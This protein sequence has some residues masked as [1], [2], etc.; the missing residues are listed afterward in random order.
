MLNT[1]DQ[2]QLA[3]DRA[4]NLYMRANAN[5]QYSEAARAVEA[6]VK[7]VELRLALEREKGAP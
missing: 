6:M 4:D 1:E 5:G 3:I 7:L 2:I